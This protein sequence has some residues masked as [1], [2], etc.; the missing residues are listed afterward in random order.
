MLAGG[1]PGGH[2]VQAGEG[3]LRGIHTVLA[4]G[5]GAVQSVNQEPVSGRANPALVMTRVGVEVVHGAPVG[6]RVSPCQGCEN[7][8]GLKVLKRILLFA[9]AT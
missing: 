2:Q 1:Q 6:R 4:R 8:T 9:H 5:E 7:T 3:R